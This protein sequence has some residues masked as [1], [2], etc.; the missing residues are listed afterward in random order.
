MP[1]MMDG[2]L[3]R[4][5]KLG[6]SRSLRVF[7]PHLAVCFPDGF[8]ADTGR[9]HGHTSRV[10]AGRPLVALKLNCM[11]NRA[12]KLQSRARRRLEA[13]PFKT[14][15]TQGF[16]KRGEPRG[17]PVAKHQPIGDLGN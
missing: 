13:R 9:A 12:N 11:P 6:R 4:A 17:N 2:W 3:P 5:G 1:S 16:M 15:L 7:S 10:G 8:S 14:S